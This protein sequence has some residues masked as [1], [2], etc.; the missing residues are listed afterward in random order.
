MGIDRSEIPLVAT[1][2]AV[3]VT[4]RLGSMSSQIVSVAVPLVGMSMSIAVSRRPRTLLA[5]VIVA[6]VVVRGS[7]QLEALRR[8]L[9]DGPISGPARVVTDPT[10][11]DFDVQA[12]LAVEDR[13]YVASMQSTRATVFKR[14]QVGETFTVVGTPRSL[15]G[16]PDGWVLSNHLDGRL[17]VES[18]T[19]PAPA[20]TWYRLANGIRSLIAR[21]GAS[22]APDD[23]ALY[24]GLVIGDDREQSEL[25][26]YRFRASGLS[27]LLAVSGQNVAFVLAI[28]SPLTRRIGPRG[29]LF[30]AIPLLGVFALITRA[31]PSVLRAVVMASIGLVAVAT[32]RQVKGIRMLSLTIVGLVVID[33]LIVHSMAFMLSVA[34]TAGLILL[35]RPISEWLR[36]PRWLTEPLAVTLAAQLATAPV[37]FTMTGSLPSV[38]TPANL[39]AVPVS[40]FVMMAGLTVGVVAGSIR[41]D[42]ASVLMWPV[43]WMVRWVDWVATTASRVPMA[44]LT[45]LRMVAL[46]GV[47]IAVVAVRHHTAGPDGRPDGLA[48]R[49]VGVVGV[50]MVLGLLIPRPAG[51]G[52]V[53]L[54]GGATLD[55]T[56]CGGTV[57]VLTKGVRAISVLES[58]TEMGITSVDLVSTDDSRSAQRAARYLE[59]QF[60]A[61]LVPDPPDPDALVRIEVDPSNPDG[62]RCR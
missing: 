42:V 62:G 33:P 38:A 17:T 34:A 40:G 7:G 54:G 41:A 8:P 56:G 19:D 51:G 50:M 53:E 9:A 25:Q 10:Q 11:R 37:L 14:A 15:D 24:L 29:S 21:S 18:I 39:L 6:V 4:A 35:A 48:R 52:L 58:L 3:V 13:R 31:E 43:T 32:G 20:A 55:R 47:V 59:E 44:Q 22:M 12:V 5:V 23:R 26:K 16:A 57:V 49:L 2:I 36:G 30:L 45:P 1:A 61:V 27:H 28:A 60:G 46:I